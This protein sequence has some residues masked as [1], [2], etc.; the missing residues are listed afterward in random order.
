MLLVLCALLHINLAGRA[1][2]GDTEPFLVEEF[3]RIN[4]TIVSRTAPIFYTFILGVLHL[5]RTPPLNDRE[6]CSFSCPIGY[7]SC[8]VHLLFIH[9]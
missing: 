9:Q 5:I 3:K 1:V 8:Y 4:P 7:Y 6:L 2:P